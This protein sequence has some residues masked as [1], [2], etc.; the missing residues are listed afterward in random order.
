MDTVELTEA[1]LDNEVRIYLEDMNLKDKKW[2]WN[3]FQEHDKWP[4]VLDEA[5]K[6]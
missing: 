1:E 3:Y 2:I 5:G 4:L 6:K